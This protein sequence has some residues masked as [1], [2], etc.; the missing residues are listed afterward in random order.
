M[1]AK[2]KYTIGGEAFATKDAITTRCRE[3]RDAT[4]DGSAVEATSEVNFLF[5]LFSTWHDEWEDKTVSGFVGFT[6]MTVH[7]NGKVTR[8][9]AIQTAEDDSIDISFQHAIRRIEIARTGTLVPQ[10]LRD[11]RNAA[12]VEIA[13][14]TMNYRATALSAGTR[15]SVTGLLLTANS[16]AVDHYGRSFDELLFAFCQL[17]SINPLKVQV[18]SVHGV[19]ARFVDRAL[20]QDWQNYHKQHARLRLIEKTENLRIP[21]VRM[22]WDALTR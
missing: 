13:R 9:F 8:C 3:I 12:R 4:P 6:T 17:H 14:Q 16:C 11:F 22:A 15:C 20:A 21:R 7:A 1:A 5:D 19:Q 2:A 18:G 10:A